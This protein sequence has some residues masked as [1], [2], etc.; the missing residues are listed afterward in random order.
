MLTFLMIISSAVFLFGLI[1]W[2]KSGAL[3]WKI[4]HMSLNVSNNKKGSPQIT[5]QK[6]ETQT[7]RLLRTSFK[8][9]GALA[10]CVFIFTITTVVM[11]IDWSTKKYAAGSVIGST[12]ER[13]GFNGNRND[14]LRS[15]GK[16]L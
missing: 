3:L 5:I 14:A 7:D 12:T 1:Q 13:A 8:V 2:A 9:L 6:M 11:N 16:K 10:L 15:M 4:R